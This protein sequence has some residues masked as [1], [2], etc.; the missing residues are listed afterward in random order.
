MDHPTP[1]AERVGTD[2][3]EPVPS[4]EAEE[5][6]LLPTELAALDAPVVIT[7]RDLR[8][9]AERAAFLDAYTR[10]RQRHELSRPPT[11]AEWLRYYARRRERGLAVSE[12]YIAMLEHLDASQPADDDEL[13]RVIAEM[14]GGGR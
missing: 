13:A 8:K 11:A 4:T 5:H 1:R 9:D 14:D 2:A 12:P 10:E 3:P 7:K 6:D